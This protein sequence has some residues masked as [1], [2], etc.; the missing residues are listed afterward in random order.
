MTFGINGIDS[1]PGP[2]DIEKQSKGLALLDAIIM[3][4]WENRYFSFNHAW[5]PNAGERMASMRNGAGG[6]YFILLSEN[7]VVGKVFDQ[8]NSARAVLELQS[9]P[10]EFS[11]FKDEAAFK[12]NDVTF[13]FY[14]RKED[15]R[16][17]S[18]PEGLSYFP[19]LRFLSDGASFYHEWAEGYYERSINKD[20]L[21][22]VFDSL[23]INE[24][25]LEILNGDLEL[26]DLRDDL[27]EILGRV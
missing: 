13:Y 5:N 24:H 19:Y 18:L 21:K 22:E 9:I 11:S 26:L 6:E 2:S 25:Q 27:E 23:S 4:D 7:G 3:P 10:D 12:L 20:V 8:L 15:L 14:R 1:L 17:F 16:W